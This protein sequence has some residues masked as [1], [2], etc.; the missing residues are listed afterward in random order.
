M[1]LR[2]ED[3]WNEQAA[4]AYDT[5]G[6]GMFDATLLAATAERL[7]TLAA[8]GRA[9]EFAIGTGRVAI[10]L[11]ERGVDVAGIEIAPAMAA[12]L[13]EKA[14]EAIPLVIGDMTRS[15]VPG[16]FSLVFLVF[17]GISNVLTQE[18]Q[19]ACFRNAAR[20]L[21]VGGRFVVE[22]WVPQL[23]RPQD[24][25]AIVVRSQPGYVVVDTY[26]VLAQQVISHHFRFGD[27][28]RASLFRS[29][30]R[31]V[32]PAELDL[33]AQLAGFELEARHADWS[34]VPFTAASRSH[35]SVYRKVRD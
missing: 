35:V 25:Q 23:P 21:G 11:Y 13:R 32:L 4:A 19:M 22:L 26:D 9:L 18:E 30:H 34:E 6:E 14:G 16:T 5:P 8:G 17:N 20:H 24:A 31:Y 15:V 2:H 10:P 28:D 7:K 12:K 33:M 27:G 3:I 1:T 29:P